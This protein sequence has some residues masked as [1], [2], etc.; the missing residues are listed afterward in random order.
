MRVVTRIASEARLVEIGG[1]LFSSTITAAEPSGRFG[2][3]PADQARQAF[4]NLQAA[5]TAAGAES[6]EIG[7]LRISAASAEAGR[8]ATTELA[9]RFPDPNDRPA[10]RVDVYPLPEGHQI[11]LQL[12][13]VRGQ[14]RQPIAPA[15]LGSAAGPAAV[16]IGDLVVSSPI[17][18]VE[19]ATGKLIADRP[20]QLRQAFANLDAVVAAA[21]GS[22]AD[23]AHIFI[24]VRDQ[25][26]NDDVLA[27]FL[28]A[29]PTAGD[30][31]V[32]KNVFADEL[33]GGAV[34][35]E[36]QMM[37]LLGR[38]KRTNYEVAGAAKKH[39]NPLGTRIGNLL[40]S[41]GIGGH[42]PAGREVERQAARALN[43]VQAL[44]EQ[45]GGSL[46]DVA[47]VTFTVDDYAHTP[48][49]EAEW[50][51]RF[52]DPATAPARHIMAFGGREGNY[53]TQIHAIAVLGSSI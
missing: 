33:Q 31:S 12:I 14:R 29:F 15:G 37:A 50:R 16:R 23:I 7:L 25:A 13:G 32:R 21:G 36:L 42:D 22:R 11:Q 39:P 27:A 53:Q 30:R 4:A 45:A 52:P 5:I 40:V 1:V 47:H 34:A 18:G 19:P 48:I 49:I 8:A 41:A 51:K 20:A 6:R 46:D 38:G 43:N 26:D 35:A 44:M 17:V 10:S 3:T 28:D 24:Y 2:S 9:A